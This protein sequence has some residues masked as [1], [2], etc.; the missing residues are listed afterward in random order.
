M[1]HTPL[2]VPQINRVPPTRELSR[3]TNRVEGYAISC[4]WYIQYTVRGL[5]WLG[6]SSSVHVCCCIQVCVCVCVCVRVHVRACVC[7]CVHVSTCA[8]VTVGA[9][10]PSI[11]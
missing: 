2:A 7:T 8:C 5:Q 4:V 3:Q 6:L 9:S 1:D 11:W 10:V